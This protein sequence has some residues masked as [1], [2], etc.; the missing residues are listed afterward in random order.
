M[1]LLIYRA[2]NNIIIVALKVHTLAITSPSNSLDPLRASDWFPAAS[3]RCHRCRLPL[4]AIPSLALPVPPAVTGRAELDA[5]HTQL[6]IYGA[7]LLSQMIRFQLIQPERTLVWPNSGNLQD[8]YLFN[9]SFSFFL[10]LKAYR[11]NCAYRR[12]H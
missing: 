5:I 2:M 6:S 1:Y 4:P 11:R 9:L 7:R 10:F 3:S 12:G 8:N